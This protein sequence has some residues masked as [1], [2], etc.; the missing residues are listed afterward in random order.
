MNRQETLEHLKLILR[1]DLNDNLSAFALRTVLGEIVRAIRSLVIQPEE[2]PFLKERN[3]VLAALQSTVMQ[4]ADKA[5]SSEH[6]NRGRKT[7][8][9]GYAARHDYSRAVS[10][11]EQVLR[12]FIAATERFES[13]DG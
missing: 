7:P 2:N 6:A 10:A 9:K 1:H 12:E 8:E 13:A 5:V 4:E 11:I 3:A